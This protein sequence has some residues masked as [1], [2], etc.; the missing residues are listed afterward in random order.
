METW[1]DF[2]ASVEW[3]EKELSLRLGVIPGYKATKSLARFVKKNGRNANGNINGIRLEKHSKY[4]KKW[5]LKVK[6]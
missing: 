1:R 4:Y 3:R 6:N 5:K 2:W